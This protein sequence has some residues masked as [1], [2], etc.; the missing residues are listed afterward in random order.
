MNKMKR[1]K[2]IGEKQVYVFIQV[3]KMIMRNAFS[4]QKKKKIKKI[5]QTLQ[6]K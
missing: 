3:R 4:Q 1:K 2:K 6:I 5:M